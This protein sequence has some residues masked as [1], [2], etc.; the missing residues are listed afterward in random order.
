MQ[1]FHDF[2]DKKNQEFE[3][4]AEEILKDLSNK[5]KT[6]VATAT[7]EME[8]DMQL[9]PKSTSE[10]LNY[11]KVLDNLAKQGEYT[12]AQRIKRLLEELEGNE[13]EN[14]RMRKKGKSTLRC[15]IFNNDTQSSLPHCR[16]GLELAEQH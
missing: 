3:N 14:A 4:E 12:E 15:R 11:R 6:E 13:L 1:N 8:A 9:K 16:K 10:M 2:W 7:E 5:N